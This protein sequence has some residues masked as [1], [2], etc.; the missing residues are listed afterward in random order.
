MLSAPGDGVASRF[1][2]EDLGRQPSS[3]MS[4]EKSLN[5]PK[6]GGIPLTDISIPAVRLRVPGHDT[7]Q[8][9]CRSIA[10]L[11]SSCFAQDEPLL[12][13]RTRA[14]LVRTE[15]LDRSASASDV[16]ARPALSIFLYRVDYHRVM[17]GPWSAVAHQDGRAHL[18]LELHFLIT[19]WA[20]NAEH[21]Y[22]ILGRA[23]QCL[24]S[25]PILSGPLLDPEIGWAT[26]DAIQI[27]LGELT[28]EEIMRTFD[29]LPVDY[30]LSVPYVARTI[31]ID[32]SATRTTP[33]VGEV[34]RGLEPTRTSGST[35]RSK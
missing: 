20:D 21:E 1:F 23:M 26:G 4:R 5:T 15:D 32:E 16:L 30:K 6:A 17:R 29:S 31:R 28:T 11:L 19:P 8:G 3:W 35:A 25:E 13:S 24:E 9:A 7:I 34:H 14:V 10:R 18:P 22:R 12:K 2:L 33:R 27:A